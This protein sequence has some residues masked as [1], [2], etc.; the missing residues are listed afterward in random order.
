MG[1]TQSSSD[2]NNLMLSKNWVNKKCF[3]YKNISL[4]DNMIS[5]KKDFAGVFG[6]SNLMKNFKF[7]IRVNKIGDKQGYIAIGIGS[8]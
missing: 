4:K 8:N 5:C 3:Y 1:K 2:Q 7:S 6:V